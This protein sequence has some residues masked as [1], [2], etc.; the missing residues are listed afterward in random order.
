MWPIFKAKLFISQPKAN[1]EVKTLFGTG[2]Y[3]GTRILKLAI[4][5]NLNFNPK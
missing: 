1:L 2:T 3:L 5:L 4:A